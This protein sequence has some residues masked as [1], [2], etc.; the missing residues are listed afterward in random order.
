MRGRMND[1]EVKAV[2]RKL[3]QLVRRVKKGE[4][5]LQNW[6]CIEKE[7]LLDAVAVAKQLSR[8]QAKKSE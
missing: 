2:V 1:E 4:G 3:E 5:V 6:V 7:L 8:M